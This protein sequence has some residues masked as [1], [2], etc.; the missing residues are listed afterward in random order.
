MHAWQR[1]HRPKLIRARSQGR[2]A[3]RCALK[4]AG[5]LAFT[6]GCVDAALAGPEVCTLDN[7]VAICQGNQSNG[8]SSGT[9][10][11]GTYTILLVNNLTANIAPASGTNGIEFTSTSPITLSVDTGPHMIVTTGG[12]IGIFTS[13]NGDVVLS[14]I[15]D[16]SHIWQQW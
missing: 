15:G 12:G 4:V 5:A 3:R 14:A 13:S 1:Q 2:L 16:I 6:L 8:I 9:D 11:P 7:P 10:F